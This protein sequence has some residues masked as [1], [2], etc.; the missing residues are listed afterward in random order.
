MGPNSTSH[1]NGIPNY[2]LLILDDI[3]NPLTGGAQHRLTK[4]RGSECV[5]PPNTVVQIIRLFNEPYLAKTGW[6]QSFFS[7]L[8]A[9]KCA[10]LSTTAVGY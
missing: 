7:H 6:A 3:M 8:E 10:P 9:V 4:I 2:M 5:S 1:C